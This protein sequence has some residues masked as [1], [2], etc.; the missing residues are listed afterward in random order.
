MVRDDRALKEI[1]V[2]DSKKL[3]P[4]RREQLEARIREVAKVELRA[5]QAD[6][7][8]RDRAE[9]S[10][11]LI[12]AEAF[13]SIVR[14]LGPRV[15]FVDAVDVDEKR[16][17]RTVRELAGGRARIV[18]RHKADSLFPVVSAASIIAKVERDRAVRAIFSELDSEP[19]SGYP[20]DPRTLAFIRKW[21]KER[22][23]LPPH[24]RASW[25][26]IRKLD[27]GPGNRKLDEW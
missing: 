9:R 7:I 14:T 4:R 1:G 10:L 23:M 16:F 24:T 3:S 27:A 20:S 22:G 21:K 17:G 15:A 2:K 6:E 25:N 5:I 19:L 18:S 26:T 11:N 13:G 12:E 8:D